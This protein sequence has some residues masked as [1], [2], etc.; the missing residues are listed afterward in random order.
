MILQEAKNAFAEIGI[1]FIVTDIANA[2]DLFASYQSGEAEM[3]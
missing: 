3:W 2:S 1:D